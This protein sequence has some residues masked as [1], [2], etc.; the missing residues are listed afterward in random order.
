MC[1]RDSPNINDEI[2]LSGY[3][4]YGT[5]SNPDQGFD[6]KKRWGSNSI[7]AISAEDLINGAS[8]LNKS[9]DKDIYVINFDKDKSFLESMISLG[10]SGSPLLIKDDQGY[11]LIGV[12]SWVKKGPDQNRGYG[13][14]AGFVSVEQNSLWINDNNP[15]RYISSISDGIWSQNSNWDE[16]SY[17]SNQSPDELN[18][19]TQ[20]AKYYSV[21]LL[22]SMNLKA[23]IEIDSL[24]IINTGYL[25][26]EPNSSLTVLLDSHIHQGSMSNQGSF[27][28]SNLY[29]ENGI[30]ENSNNSSFE[31]SLRIIN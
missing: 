15:L 23:S 31:N 16:S 14:T 7:S 6:R 3:G 19:S 21:S 12:A 13:S 26:L 2:Y 28:S 27:S 25:E 24:N 22:N 4:L 9:L 18:Y 17:P 1:I 11:L 5:G 8:N 29:I 10:D 30:F 20:S